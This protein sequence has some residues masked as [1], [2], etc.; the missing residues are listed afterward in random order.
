MLIDSK[1]KGE[2]HGAS[3]GSKLKIYVDDYV[4]L[5]YEFHLYQEQGRED[6]I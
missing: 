2:I 1:V 6:H 4:H 3:S 5:Q